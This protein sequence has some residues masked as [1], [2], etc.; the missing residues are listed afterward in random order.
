[1]IGMISNSFGGEGFAKYI[2]KEE[3]GVSLDPIFDDVQGSR[4]RGA[5]TQYNEA[6]NIESK[7]MHGFFVE[8]ELLKRP[9]TKLPA[10]T[11]FGNFN[12]DEEENRL[13]ID[14]SAIPADIV[15]RLNESQL[16]YM[17][18]AI[19]S[20]VSVAQG[21]PG[22]GKSAALS[23]INRYFVANKGERTVGVAM[24]SK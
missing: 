21:P 20:K 4:S 24:A 23:V 3:T 15:D 12:C 5:V 22:T 14:N 1:M 6:L 19:V 18:L 8:P 11:L 17:R 10:N 9:P 16:R 2:D 13:A 7:K